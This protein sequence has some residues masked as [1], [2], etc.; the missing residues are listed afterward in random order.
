M[1]VY[2][3]MNDENKFLSM[4]GGLTHDW[5]E[6]SK[7]PVEQIERRLKFYGED[8]FLMEYSVEEVNQ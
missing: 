4:S 6:A 7:F 8:F 3:L 2:A 5:F 1:R